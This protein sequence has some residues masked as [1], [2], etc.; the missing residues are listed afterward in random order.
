MIHIEFPMSQIDQKSSTNG[1]IELDKNYIVHGTEHPNK[2]QKI[3]KCQLDY[4][5]VQK[6]ENDQN[7][8]R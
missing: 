4:F 3:H 1:K 7:C 6:H 8:N 5:Y 2:I